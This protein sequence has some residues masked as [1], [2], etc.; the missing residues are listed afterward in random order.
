M[1]TLIID[2]LPSLCRV[3]LTMLHLTLK[4]Y[5][6]GIENQKVKALCKDTYKNIYHRIKSMYSKYFFDS[7][8]VEEFSPKF[9]ELCKPAIL[10][11]SVDNY[12]SKSSLLDIFIVWSRHSNT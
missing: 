7:Y 3:L 4:Y 6:W 10:N 11:F 1:G 2:F 5:R 9:L 8:L 12:Q